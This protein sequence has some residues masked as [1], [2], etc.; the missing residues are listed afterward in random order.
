MATAISFRLICLDIPLYAGVISTDLLFS[1]LRRPSGVSAVGSSSEPC[2][3]K[4]TELEQVRRTAIT[5]SGESTLLAVK[6]NPIR[7]HA[8]KERTMRKHAPGSWLFT[9]AIMSFTTLAVAQRVDV[10]AILTAAPKIATSVDGVYAFPAPPKGFNPLTADD[11]QLLTY[12]LPERPDQTT[13]A[14]GYSVSQRSMPAQ[15]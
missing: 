14:S 2:L 4:R 11:A 10:N 6:P 7:I 12:G 3:R 1:V 5:T 15:K 13:A 8:V 9:L